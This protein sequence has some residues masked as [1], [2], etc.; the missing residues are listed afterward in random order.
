M[1]RIDSSLRAYIE[2]AIIPMYD[3]FDS[4]HD[5]RHVLA[6]VE[7]SLRLSSFYPVN[8]NM[9]YASAAYHDTGLR[10]G[11]RLHHLESGRIVRH[12]TNLPGW[13]TSDQIE[14]IAQAAEDHRA[15]SDGEPRSIYGKIVAESDRQIIPETVILRAVQY[16]AHNFPHRDREFHW[17]RFC[18]HMDEKYAKGG[19]L[20]LYIP[21]SRNAEGLARLRE[22]IS[23]RALLRDC[24]DSAYAVAFKNK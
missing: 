12:D 20:K 19:Y 21:E 24:F 10:A 16:G 7:E 2:T 5:R 9:V 18:D 14:T 17:Q 8:I 1:E 11:R 6:V 4:G 22:I 23:D 13:F 15:S 3:S